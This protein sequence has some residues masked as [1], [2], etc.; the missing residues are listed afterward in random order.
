ML[1]KKIRKEDNY[2]YKISLTLL[3]LLFQNVDSKWM[4]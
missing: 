1:E 3:N 4:L 2:T